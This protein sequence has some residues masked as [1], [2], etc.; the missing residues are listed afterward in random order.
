MTASG[1]TGQD[2][3]LIADALSDQ[4]RRL[5]SRARSKAYAG[6]ALA[7]ARATV[8][9][10]ADRLAELAMELGQHAHEPVHVRCEDTGPGGDMTGG[11]E[12]GQSL[13]RIRDRG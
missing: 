6:P 2:M 9:E 10:Q 12:R 5:A 3:R 11:G 4:S 1:I 8:R 7:I 13:A